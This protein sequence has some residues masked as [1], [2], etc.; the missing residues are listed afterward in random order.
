M[1]LHIIFFSYIA[2]SQSITLMFANVGYW[3]WKW[4]LFCLY[5][6]NTS[7]LGKWEHSYSSFLSSNSSI[8][9]I[10]ENYPLYY[11]THQCMKA[12]LIKTLHTPL[13][14][15][16]SFN[17]THHYISLLISIMLIST[18][19]SLQSDMIPSSIATHEYIK[20][21]LIKHSIFLS[22]SILQE[23]SSLNLNVSVPCYRLSALQGT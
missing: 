5:Y 10:L 8:M 7:V 15:H 17:Q 6:V 20:C 21:E 13:L 11:M 2:N 18:I 23:R 4:L 14:I 9:L 3:V 16:C 12:A 19:Q 1:E 22:L